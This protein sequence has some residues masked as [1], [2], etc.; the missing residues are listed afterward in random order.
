MRANFDHSFAL[1]LSLFLFIYNISENSLLYIFKP[2]FYSISLDS[3]GKPLG[4]LE[5]QKPNHKIS[6]IQRTRAQIFPIYLPSLSR[7]DLFQ[8]LFFLWMKMGTGFKAVHIQMQFETK[9]NNWQLWKQITMIAL[10]TFTTLMM[11]LFGLSRITVAVGT[12]QGSTERI[13]GERKQ[14]SGALVWVNQIVLLNSSL[15]IWITI[16]LKVSY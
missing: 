2:L 11:M 15:K 3:S 7:K 8:L 9:V 4:C 12:L 1:F 6:A 14:A 13:R 10:T 16:N 5:L